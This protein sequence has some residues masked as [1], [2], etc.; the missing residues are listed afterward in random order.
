MTVL[1]WAVLVLWSAGVLWSVSLALH[2]RRREAVLAARPRIL[3]LL[4][5]GPPRSVRFIAHEVGMPAKAIRP[6]V[7]D[8][9]A[10]GEVRADGGVG[11]VAFALP[12]A[13]ECGEEDES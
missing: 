2:A 13:L 10:R 9:A 8:M 7:W 3:A 4:A 11:E 5:G 6:L 1:S 12:E